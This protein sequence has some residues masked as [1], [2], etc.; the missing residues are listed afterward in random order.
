MLKLLYFQLCSSLVYGLANLEQPNGSPIYF[1]SWFDRLHGDTPA[2]TNNRLNYRPFSL[3]QSD[4]NITETLQG[5]YFDDI[6][7]K[8]QETGT[9]AAV[10][11]TVYP[12]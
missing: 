3:F 6:F 1:G 8:I 5:D 4:V 12:I 7:K 10:Y 11:L 9:D 2:A